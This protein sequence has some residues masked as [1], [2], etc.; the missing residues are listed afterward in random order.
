MNCVREYGEGSPKNT[1]RIEASGGGLMKEVALEIDFEERL[2]FGWWKW[3]M[4]KAFQG[5]EV[6]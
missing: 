4:G 6:G 1:C 5:E 2:G 3:E